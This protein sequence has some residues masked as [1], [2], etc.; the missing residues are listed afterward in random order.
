MAVERSADGVRSTA[1]LRLPTLVAV[2]LAGFTLLSAGTALA[3]S[4][5]QVVAGSPGVDTSPVVAV[6]SAGT[7]YVAWRNNTETGGAPDFVQYCVLPAGASACSHAGSLTPVNATF[8]DGVNIIVDGSTVVVLA[9]A[10]GGHGNSAADY[11][12]EQ[13]WQSTDSGATFNI[14]N[15]GLS[16]SDGI[17]NADTGPLNGVIVPGTNV[18]GFAWDT[19][20]G[21]PTFN[22]FPLTS[23]PECSQAKH[24]PFATLQPSSQLQL[25]NV[26]GAFAAQAGAH[27]GVLGVF[28][29]LGTSAPYACP[30][31]D[32]IPYVYGSGNQSAS[33]DYNVSPGSPN[34]AWQRALSLGVCNAQ[35]PAVGGGPSGFGI[36]ATNEANGTTSYWPFDQTNTNFDLPPV[37]LSKQ[38]ELFASVNQDG[39]GG[40]YS[41]WQYDGSGGRLALSYSGDVGKTWIGPDIINPSVVP[42]L[43]SSVG[44]GGQGWATW[45]NNGVVYAQQFNKADAAPTSIAGAASSTSK[46]VTVTVSCGAV[47]CTVT[48]TIT[49]TFPAADVAR[50][51]HTKR[52]ATVL[53]ARGTFTIRKSGPQHLVLRLTKSGRKDL[54][55]RHG[56]TRAT[57]VAATTVVNDI[58]KTKRAIKIVPAR[59]KK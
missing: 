24:C 2:I 52:K 31:H 55:A 19:A 43:R 5:K 37:V 16:V 38:G 4:G 54:A 28:S 11:Q 18:L 33:N 8:I 48:I 25:G 50:A 3:A 26:G 30:N 1:L 45:Q 39:G 46:T 53:L 40:V 9:D 59:H 29:N 7:A 51:G 32:N 57:L 14:V 34:S 10:Y 27:P 56:R 47:P 12:P 21:P 35:N 49:I 15:G 23:A 6:D 42:N 41:T 58:V 17:L 44:S 13:E 20:A 22:A 36:V